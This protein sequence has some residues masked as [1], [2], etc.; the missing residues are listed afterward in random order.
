MKRIISILMVLAVVICMIPVTSAYGYITEISTYEE[1]VQAAADSSK[2]Y[3]D[4]Y[5][6]KLVNDIEQIDS[7][8]DNTVIVQ[9]GNFM[10]DLNGFKVKRKTVSLDICLF[11]VSGDSSVILEDTSAEKTG[12]LEFENNAPGYFYS[13]VNCGDGSLTILGGN[14]ILKSEQGGGCA[15]VRATSGC[16]SIYDGYFDSTE[17]NSADAIALKHENYVY[18]PP[19]CDVYGGEFRSVY[20]SIEINCMG[21]YSSY[22]ALYPSV[23]VMGGEFYI[24][25]S[26]EHNGFAY[27]NNGWGHVIVAE[28]TTYFKCLNA[29]DR[30]YVQG[31]KRNSETHELDGFKGSY[32]KVSAPSLI[33]I[34][35]ES[36]KADRLYELCARKEAELLLENK[37]IEKY[38]GD[39]LR[40]MLEP[41]VYTVGQYELEA[42]YIG[43]H[44]FTNILGIKW[45][46]ADESV[47][48][49]EDT[50]WVEYAD[51]RNMPNWKFPVRHAEE[52]TFYIRMLV[53]YADGSFDEDVYAVR[54]EEKGKIIEGEVTIGGSNCDYGNTVEAIVT[55]AP[56]EQDKAGYEYKWTVGDT[57]VGTGKS[58]TIS[59]PNYITLQLT[60]TVTSPGYEGALKTTPVKIGFADNNDDPVFPY[61][62]YRSGTVSIWNVTNSQ[63]YLF[64]EKYDRESL[65]EEDWENAITFSQYTNSLTVEELGLEED[66]TIYIYT[67]LA[68]T[69]TKKAGSKIVCVP[70]YLGV[71]AKLD[72]LEFEGVINNTIYIP[73][74][75]AGEIYELYYD[76]DPVNANTWNSFSFRTSYPLS[77]VSP[78]GKVTVN[79]YTGVVEVKILS[80]GTTTLFASYITQ[81]ENFYAKINIVVYDPTD[82]VIGPANVASDIKDET[83]A[84]GQTHVTEMPR[85]VPE[86]ASY[87]G[88]RWYLGEST[89]SGWV[90][91]EENHIAKIDT[92]TG[93]ITGLNPG[94]VFV[95][96]VGDRGVIDQFKLTVTE[97]DGKLPVEEVFITYDSLELKVGDIRVLNARIYP[98]NATVQDVVW[99]TSDIRVVTVDENGRLKAVGQGEAVITATVDGV[100]DECRITVKAS[101]LETQ[102]LLGDV[103]LDGRVNAMDKVAITKLIRSGE[104]NELA[105]VNGDGKINALDKVAVT[106]I[107]KGKQ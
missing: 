20:S 104:A 84:V 90:T 96:L 3:S 51:Y 88:L 28:G 62:S 39:E 21:N 78:T 60:C 7:K 73:F 99:S 9:G 40:A 93:V 81:T 79:N 48:R 94:N 77:L 24:T 10:L 42:P 31:V 100:A 32:Y 35:N 54:F 95:V 87:D 65:T 86:P 64:T 43:G 106:K 82:P 37:N 70:L 52:I 72:S 13:V 26:H 29:S 11:K 74:T 45:Y 68:H 5:R 50:P 23:Y 56:A 33:N 47:Y 30:I 19:H 59:N 85:I 102:I 92:T 27:C 22:G 36:T 6:C 61:V 1:L 12:T 80:V 44:Y 38:F 25:K 58:Y 16:I 69:A 18:Q 14:Y 91:F 49:G 53:E 89:Q 55:G 46:M 71:E 41:S 105:D 76:T 8:N 107:I 97:P 75:E 2:Y 83:I 15:T 57:T 34:N 67:R 98:A 66:K 4:Y 17:A 103:N 63:E 101:G